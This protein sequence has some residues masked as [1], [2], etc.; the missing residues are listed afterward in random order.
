MKVGGILKARTNKK[1]R[2]PSHGFEAIDHLNTNYSRKL[3]THDIRKLL[4]KILGVTT[5]SVALF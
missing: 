5:D 4:F 3:N 1:A 2:K